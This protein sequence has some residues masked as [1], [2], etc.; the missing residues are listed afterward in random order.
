MLIA[1][2]FIG[3]LAGATIH[4]SETAVALVSAFIGGGV[5]MNVTRHELPD[6][7]PNSVDAFLLSAASYTAVLLCIHS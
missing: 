7:N 4:L 2:L 3:W 5:I 6:E 1:S